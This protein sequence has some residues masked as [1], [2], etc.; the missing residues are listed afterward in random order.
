MIGIYPVKG[1]FLSHPCQ[2]ILC[3]H[4]LIS[5]FIPL[6]SLSVFPHLGMKGGRHIFAGLINNNISCDVSNIIIASDTMIHYKRYISKPEADWVTF[7]HGAGGSSSI[8][9][10]QIR[11]FQEHYNVLLLDLRGHGKSTSESL[12]ELKKY[13]FSKIS[14]EILEVLEH[15]QIQKSHFIGISLGTILIREIA[16][17]YPERIHSMI[18][19]GAVMDF[20][21]RGRLLLGMGNLFK[22]IVP[23]M[24]LY[25]LFAH[26]IMPK[27]QHKA[28]RNLFIRE[29]RNLYQ[30]EFKRWFKLTSQ[31]HPML[32]LFRTKATN[33]PT[34][35]I[36]G[37]EDYMFL[38]AI[39]KIAKEQIAVRLQVIPNCGHV[40]NVDQANVF[41]QS[42]LAFLGK[43]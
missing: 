2:N 34:L 22:S 14:D 4:N 7:V 19:G 6:S 28:S 5:F 1:L 29:A 10:K 39:I 23:Y 37:E 11:A 16:E 38:P 35:Y 43:Q 42:A 24:L 33:I 41:N 25:K 9:F 12:K 31:M 40:V 27:A 15:L 13:S 26:I 36:M 21:L 30:K 18:M 17:R 8:W 32:R 20:N 3:A